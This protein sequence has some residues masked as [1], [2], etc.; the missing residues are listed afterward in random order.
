MKLNSLFSA[1]AIV[2]PG[3]F[4]TVPSVGPDYVR[5]ETQT[6][7][8]FRDASWVQAS[9]SEATPRGAWWT[10]FS[11]PGLDSLEARALGRNQDLRAMAARVEEA[12]ASAGIARS[13]FWPQVAAQPAFTRSRMSTTTDNPFPVAISN[14]YSLPLFAT[15][16][17]DLFGRVR[18]LS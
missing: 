9:P 4:A 10:V 7:P 3:A 18:R 5:P 11:D 13:A 1:L 15:W 12:A 6:P 2:A 16:E 17:I 14:D 8:A